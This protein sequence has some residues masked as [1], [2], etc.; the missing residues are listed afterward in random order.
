MQNFLGSVCG[1]QEQARKPTIGFSA[2][3]GNMIPKKEMSQQKQKRG[4][5]DAAAQLM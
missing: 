4:R 5:K 2:K 1:Q 3:K